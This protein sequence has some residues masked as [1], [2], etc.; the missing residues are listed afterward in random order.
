MSEVERIRAEIDMQELEVTSA[1]ESRAVAREILAVRQATRSDALA[2][3]E[4]SGIALTPAQL[5]MHEHEIAE[6]IDV[7][8][9]KMAVV[10]TLMLRLQE[11]KLQLR[12]AGG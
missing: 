2:N 8:N 9:K 12:L 7:V 11:L 4:L 1:V 3:A 5:E 10:S 6:G